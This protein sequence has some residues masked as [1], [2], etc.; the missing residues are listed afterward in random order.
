MARIQRIYK[1]SAINQLIFSVAMFALIW[2]NF[3]DGFFTFKMQ[4]SYLD[5][6]WIF[7][8]IGIY[9]IIDMGTG[10]NSQIIG[11]STRWRFE[12]FTGIILLAIT[13]PLNYI[14]TKYTALGIQGPAIANLFSFTVYNF[15]RYWF[16]KT[17]YNLQPFTRH[18]VYTILLGFACYAVC[19]LLFDKYQG[20]AWIVIRS[21][22]FL[23]LY[24]SG[25][26]FLNLSADVIPIW[27]T[28]LKRTGIKKGD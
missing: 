24:I 6:R 14:L 20:F 15:I 27:H 12:F 1:Q 4:K 18:T 13:L 25:T 10:V 2:L 22:A 7:F 9:R 16:L 8:F 17:K 23:L 28:V 5:A 19:Y 26:L 11:T 21:S 3:T